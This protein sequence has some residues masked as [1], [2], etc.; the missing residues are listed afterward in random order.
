M[1]VRACAR[2]IYRRR[3]LRA[4]REHAVRTRV[5]YDQG[6]RGYRRRFDEMVLQQRVSPALVQESP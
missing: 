6:P 2:R 3:V 1:L 5:P 4:T